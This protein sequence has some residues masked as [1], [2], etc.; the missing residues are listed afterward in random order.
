MSLVFNMSLV[1]TSILI[2]RSRFNTHKL[3][4][5]HHHTNKS[6][7]RPIEPIAI[8]DDKQNYQK[9]PST[10][11]REKLYGRNVC[12][13]GEKIRL[14]YKSFAKTKASNIYESYFVTLLQFVLQQH[15][16]ENSQ[17]FASCLIRSCAYSGPCSIF[18]RH[19]RAIDKDF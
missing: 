12:F 4:L 17:P 1:Q 2:Y 3:Y 11:S 15:I 14:C 7:F 10:R 8:K 13:N 5:G 16:A 19:P 9:H 18:I 6:P